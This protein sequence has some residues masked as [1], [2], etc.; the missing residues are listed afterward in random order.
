MVVVVY[1]LILSK[2]VLEM[3]RFG[4]INVYGL[5]L[6]RWRGVVLI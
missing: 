1:G 5:L 6:L 2:V 3:S 4:C